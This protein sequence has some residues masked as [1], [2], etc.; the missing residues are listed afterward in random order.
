MR[1]RLKTKSAKYGLDSINSTLSMRNCLIV[2]QSRIWIHIYPV[3]CLNVPVIPIST[4]PRDT[5]MHTFGTP[6]DEP[7]ESAWL[8]CHTTESEWKVHIGSESV[9][10]NDCKWLVIYCSKVNRSWF[11]IK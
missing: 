6:L 9:A 10:T 5:A 2:W 7:L 8:L 3:F 4:G 11:I 1:D